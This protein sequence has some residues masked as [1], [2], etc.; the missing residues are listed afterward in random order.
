[1]KPLHELTISV[2]GKAGDMV[3][4]RVG[5]GRGNLDDTGRYGVQLRRHVIPTDYRTE[6]QQQNRRRMAAAVA[7]WQGLTPDE[8]HAW[9]QKAKHQRRTGFNL[10]I[11][12]F[13]RVHPVTEF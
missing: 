7:A 2:R 1:M 3:Y 13:C 10:F 8:W 4:Q 11:R 5:K 6:A 12:Q 9:N